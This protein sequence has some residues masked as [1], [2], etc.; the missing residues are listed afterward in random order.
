M[1]NDGSDSETTL[2][3]RSRQNHTSNGHIT[4]SGERVIDVGGSRLMCSDELDMTR[5]MIGRF[6]E[7]HK[8]LASA[9]QT[10]NTG[11]RWRLHR[12]TSHPTVRTLYT[13]SVSHAYFLCTFSLRDV[14]TRT[15]MAQGVCSA[16][17]VSLHLTF[18]IIMFHPP[19]L[20][21]P[22]GHFDT[23]FPSAPSLPNCSRSESAG[24]A[25]FRTSGEEF[26]YLADPTHSTGSEPKESTRLLLQ[27]ETRRLST[28]R[29]AMKS[30]TYRKSHARTLDC[31]VFPQC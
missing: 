4:A 14:Q 25:H 13:H 10:C 20:L 16:H 28:T 11:K 29:T 19:S 18:C 7:V 2:F 23:S 9:S 17:V 31:S 22:H 5:S 24:Q 15:G 26:D 30:L 12:S 1:S 3:V 21:F 8:M 27:M 6:T